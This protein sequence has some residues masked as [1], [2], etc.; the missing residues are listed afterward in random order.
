MQLHLQ[1]AE[2]LQMRGE[3]KGDKTMSGMP[4]ATARGNSTTTLFTELLAGLDATPDGGTDP[5]PSAAPASRLI[6]CTAELESS[7][8]LSGKVALMWGS[9]DLDVF[10]RSLFMD[11][12]DGE[13]RGLP[14]AMA[15]ELMFLAKTNKVLRAMDA[16]KKLGLS[17][18]DAHRLIDESDEARLVAIQSRSAAPEPMVLAAKRQATAD[19]FWRI[20]TNGNFVIYLMV[21][22]I[23][24]LLAWILS[25]QA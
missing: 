2:E 18:R 3:N 7:Q 16:V 24:G 12:R 14:A 13:R 10:I 22:T 17:F 8:H 4:L 15:A 5:A 19:G 25:R 11:S 21:A 1:E 20:L 23:F 6:H 9:S